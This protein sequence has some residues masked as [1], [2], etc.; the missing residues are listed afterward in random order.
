MVR[1]MK[2]KTKTIDEYIVEAKND[3]YAYIL[4]WII[5]FLILLYFAYRFNNYYLL[6]IDVVFLLS[7]F[8][9]VIIHSNLKKIKEYLVKN[10]LINKI[11]KIDYW[12]EKSYFLT[13]KY[14]ILIENNV[15]TCFEYNKIKKIRKEVTYTLKSRNN[16]I[17]EYLYLVLDNDCEYEFLISTTSI[18][19]EN[20]YDFT[21]YILEKNSNVIVEETIT[22]INNHKL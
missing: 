21:S 17:F 5:F 20:F 19:S 6:F 1:C 8:N 16:N 14:V 11:G 13:E 3:I 15:V 2:N 7:V 22:K 4:I 10:K 12:N 18:A 9:R